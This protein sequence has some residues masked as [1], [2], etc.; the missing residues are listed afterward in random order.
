MEDTKRMDG[1]D[2]IGD[3]HGH[4]DKLIGLL[5]TLG[6]QEHNGVFGHP[7]RRAIF[8]GD[9]ID[10]GR[11]NLR[12]MQ[13]V[14]AMHDAQTAHVIMGN[15]EFNAVGF[16][17]P[18]P[19]GD[20]FLRRH[21]PENVAHH[22]EFLEEIP[23]PVE[24]QPWLDWFKTL[25]LF[26]DLGPFRVVHA[27]W[28]EPSLNVLK[29]YLNADNSLL[30]HAWVPAFDESHALYRATET[31]LKGVEVDLPKGVSFR[32]HKDKERWQVRISWW[33]TA[34]E[35]LA[36][37]AHIPNPARNKDALNALADLSADP[38]VLEEFSYRGTK[39]VF[40]GHYWMKGE[41]HLQSPLC[42]CVD[43]SAGRNGPLMAYR[44]SG[45]TVLNPAHFVGFLPTAD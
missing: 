7:S 22:I 31:V 17:I 36:A 23:D 8:I 33:E 28:H 3:V 10:N 14:K 26:L 19:G 25:P 20:D 5:E 13:I 37:I 24:R 40:F 9:L 35:S 2:I 18:R 1:F 34:P 16:A 45:E 11:Q 12:V 41:P 30:E 6:Y 4:A 39:P 38:T 27:C 21:I 42:A 44:W 43:Y 32:D 29:P 15:H